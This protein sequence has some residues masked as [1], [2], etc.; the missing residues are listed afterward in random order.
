[1]KPVSLLPH[2]VLKTSFMKLPHY[3][4]T[5]LKNAVIMMDNTSYRSVLLSKALTTSSREC[6]VTYIYRLQKSNICHD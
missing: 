3:A 4:G 5:K 6:E 2:L 1:M